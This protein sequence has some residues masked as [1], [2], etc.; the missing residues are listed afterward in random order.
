MKT[1]KNKNIKL[2]ITTEHAKVLIQALE[3]Y[4]RLQSGQVAM[5][6]D[7]VYPDRWLTWE[8]K[9]HIENTIRYYAFPQN[10]KREYDGHGGFYDQ[11]DNEYGENGE[12]A[13]E[14]KLW[15][16]FKKRPHL[17]HANSSFG[18]GCSEMWS[19]TVAFE[20]KKV[21]EEY[22]H[23]EQNDGYRRPCDV[24]G[25]GMYHSYS[26]I[27]VP[28]IEGFKPELKFKI[29][30]RHKKTLD[31][32]FLVK[33]WEKLWEYIETTVFKNKQLPRGERTKIE[34]DDKESWQLIVEKPYVIESTKK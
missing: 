33:D 9:L 4:S 12:I 3:T 27:P 7:E 10:V 6:M 21:L 11:Y 16:R 13:K 17:D 19:G 22:F 29:S 1:E 25:D 32:L 20:L 28:Q 5:A 26:G 34:K 23:Y 2:S 15:E 31:D 8:E 24:S 18:V 30:N 14:S